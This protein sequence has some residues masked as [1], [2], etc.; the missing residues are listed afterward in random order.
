MSRGFLEVGMTTGELT[1]TEII[2]NA[3]AAVSNL[4]GSH[5]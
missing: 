2:K 4:P 5:R 3:Q 1:G